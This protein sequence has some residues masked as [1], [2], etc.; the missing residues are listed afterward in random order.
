[1]SMGL[2]WLHCG[3]SRASSF[4]SAWGEILASSLPVAISASVASTAGPPALV[5]LQS[6][7]PAR[8]ARLART[9]ALVKRAPRQLTRHHPPR[10]TPPAPP[11]PPPPPPPAR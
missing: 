11:S 3:G 6:P 2:P 9:P 4:D 7:L 8:R 5:P 1:M 10:P